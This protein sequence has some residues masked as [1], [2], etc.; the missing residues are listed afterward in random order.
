[1]LARI[2]PMQYNIVK[3]GGSGLGD[4]GYAMKTSRN[5]R[6]EASIPGKALGAKQGIN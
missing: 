1:M 6:K 2:Q 3:N 5:V 4:A